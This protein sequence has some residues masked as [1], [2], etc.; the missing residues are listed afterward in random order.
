MV[1]IAYLG[2]TVYLRENQ[3]ATVA[4]IPKTQNSYPNKNR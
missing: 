2:E 4:Y 3:K 1:N